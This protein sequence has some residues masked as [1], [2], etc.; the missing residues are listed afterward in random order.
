MT[1]PIANPANVPARTRRRQKSRPL[2]RIALVAA[3]LASALFALPTVVEAV[4]GLPQVANSLQGPSSAGGQVALSGLEQ[5]ACMIF[6]H[7]SKTVFVDAGHGGLDPGVVGES[8]GRPL[9]EK[10]VTLAVATRL[11]PLLQSDGYRVVLSRTRDS[12]VTKLS[13]DDSVSGSL[14]A[15]GEHRDLVT[16]A[17]C[18]NAA[19]ASVMLSIHFDAFDDPSVGGTETLYDD[20][21]PFSSANKRLAIDVQSAL[22]SAL[23][24]ADRGVWPDDQMGTPALTPE[25]NSYG[26]LVLLGPAEPGYVDNPSRMPGALVEPLFLTNP[27]DAQ[28]AG[29]PAGQQR[30]AVALKQGLEKYLAGS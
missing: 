5:G 1:P 29:S 19:A 21:R 12:S 22:V 9:N 27:T 7:G 14:T 3:L 18:A 4:R 2:L 25:G 10:D 24:T 28:L 6:G 13:V 8:G 30:I 15:S 23:G 20:A 17:A 16:R 26:H 11:A